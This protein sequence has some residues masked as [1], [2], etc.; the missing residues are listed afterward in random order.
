MTTQ[1]Q[2]TRIG[3]RRR[4]Q[5]SDL[6]E[7]VRRTIQAQGDATERLIGWVQLAVVLTFAALYAISPKTFPAEQ[8]FRPVPWAIGGYMVFTLIRLALAYRISLPGWFLLVSIVIDMALLFGLIW[9]FHIQYMQPASFYLKAPTL[10]YVF[11]FIALR[12]LRFEAR[13]VLAAGV[14]AALG[15]LAMVGYVISIDPHDTMITRNYVEYMTSNSILLGAE[16]DKIVSILVVAAILGVALIRGRALLVRSV[17]ESVAAQEL[18]RFFAP[19]VAQRIRGSDREIAAGSGEIREA[20]VV[21][22]DMRG[23][24]RLAETAEP[25]RVMG[26]LAAYQHHVVPVIQAH[27]GSID[28]FLGDGIMATFGAA[29]PS[30]AYAADALRAVEEAIDKTR[31]WQEDRRARGEACPEVNAAIASGRVIFGAVGDSSRLEYT[32]I[33]DAVNLSA[34]LEQHNKQL[35]TRALCDAAT[36]A[37]ALAQGYVPA[38]ERRQI[39]ASPV[40]GV[41]QPVDV[42]VLAA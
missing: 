25:D 20:A 31:R 36:Y 26:L 9:S 15:W 13:F 24:T 4:G 41:G 42:V 22:F 35:G 17:A 18:S 33:G 10:L 19:E 3:W 21:N 34:K 12:A 30:A 37:R 32:V 8:T 38:G 27:G 23:F 39:A 16:F 1:A 14:V 28:K 2:R 5:D 6:P 7:R 40:A 29:Q 11:I